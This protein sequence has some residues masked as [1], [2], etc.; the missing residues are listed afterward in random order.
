MAFFPT[1]W[2]AAVI[3]SVTAGEVAYPLITS[4]S[5]I[6]GTGFIKC[7]PITCEGRRVAAAI[8]VMEM[9]EVLLARMASGK[10]FSSSSRK[11]RSLT[12]SFSVAASM[13]RSGF[14]DAVFYLLN[15]MNAF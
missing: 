3:L 13:I 8:F 10:A 1:V 7:M 5:F 12:D 4:T 2:S 9:E 6:S 15:R 14:P 11:I